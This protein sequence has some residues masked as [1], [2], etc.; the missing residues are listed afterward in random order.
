MSRTSDEQAE[1][2][3]RK[4]WRSREQRSQTDAAQD[5]AKNA[6]GWSLSQTGVLN[7]WQR[8]SAGRYASLISQRTRPLT[9]VCHVRRRQVAWLSGSFAPG[10][11][12]HDGAHSPGWQKREVSKDGHEITYQ[13]R[14]GV[15][16]SATVPECS[17]R[18]CLLTGGLPRRPP[19]ALRASAN[20]VRPS[21]GAR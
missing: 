15:R 16:F 3:R 21:C 6:H 13:L 1:H 8:T 14:E 2:Y 4:D 17:G 19:A 10:K 18:R 12:S 7:H 11:R 9:S 20:M 5:A